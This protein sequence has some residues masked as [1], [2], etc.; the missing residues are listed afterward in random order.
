MSVMTFLGL[1]GAVGVGDEA[2]RGQAQFMGGV[3]PIAWVPVALSGPT[4]CQPYG[5]WKLLAVAAARL[6]MESE[7]NGSLEWVRTPPIN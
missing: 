1:R 6:G 3:R 5:W 2:P 7:F 4:H